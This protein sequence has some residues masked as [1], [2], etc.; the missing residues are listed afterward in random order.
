MA[1]VAELKADGTLLAA[2]RKEPRTGGII[3]ATAPSLK[4]LRDRMAHDPFATAG[5]ARFS[6]TE[7]APNT[8]HPGFV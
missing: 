5:V 3:L 7:F 1:F 6:F 2:G 4:A 8:R